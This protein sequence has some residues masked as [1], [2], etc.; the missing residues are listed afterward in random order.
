MKPIKQ[1]SGLPFFFVGIAIIYLSLYQPLQTAWQMQRWQ[2]TPAELIKAE[3]TRYQHRL[4]DESR[5]MYDLVMEYRYQVDGVSYTG[6][7]ASISDYSS[8]D[9]GEHY[10][11]LSEIQRQ[12]QSATGLQVWVNPDNPAEAVF[13]RRP[14]WFFLAIVSLVGGLFILIGGGLPVYQLL[15]GA[16]A[17]KAPQTDPDSPWRRHQGWRSSQIQSNARAMYRGYWLLALLVII[18]TAFCGVELSDYAPELGMVIAPFGGVVALLLACKAWREQ[19]N[20]KVFQQIP[21]TLEP[22][23]GSIG[24]QVSG[25]LILPAAPLSAACYKVS[26]ESIHHWTEHTGREVREVHEVVWEE[27]Q[28]PVIQ[29][30]DNGTRLV[31]DFHIPATCQPTSEPDGDFHRWVLQVTADLPQGRFNRHYELPV[32][33]TEQSLTS[34]VLDEHLTMDDMVDVHQDTDMQ[35]T[36]DAISLRSGGSENGW[37]VGAIGATLLVAGALFMLLVEGEFGS[38]L[39]SIGL[40]F[41]MAGVWLAGKSFHTRISPLQCDLEVYI[42]DRLV[43]KSSLSSATIA[44][45]EVYS[46]M[47]GQTEKF[48]LR[49][50]CENGRVMDV[51]GDFSSRQNAEYMRQEIAGIIGLEASG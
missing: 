50:H 27:A 18:I 23:P 39:L 34:N 14:E 9:R 4:D 40:L 21:V 19:R 2:P 48:A 45:I 41:A 17:V 8:N 43:H 3:V 47:G 35:I 13:D 46:R 22:F 42:F 20:W 28:S 44:E 1:L 51:S 38:G 16:A 5:A 49:L 36:G 11:R 12:Q 30:H 29:G 25:S 24:G 32:Y 33:V 6:N 26:L 37:K 7:R 15:S 10:A 31:F